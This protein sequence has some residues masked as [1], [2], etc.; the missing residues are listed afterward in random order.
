MGGIPLINYAYGLPIPTK[1]ND[2]IGEF[3]QNCQIRE[4]ISTIFDHQANE[5]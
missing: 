4:S 3:C 2:K 5:I 1:L